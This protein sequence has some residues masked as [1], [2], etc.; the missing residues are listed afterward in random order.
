MNI[1]EISALFSVVLPFLLAIISY[2]I[3][4][5]SKK[6]RDAFVII[7]CG[8]V[9]I[10][11]L[12]VFYGANNGGVSVSICKILCFG[13]YFKADGFRGLYL[14]VASLLWFLSSVFCKSY[15]A[16]HYRNRNRFFFFFL[17]TLG[18]VCGIFLSDDLFTLFIFFEIMSFTSYVWVAHDETPDAMRAAG[19]YLGISVIGGLSILMGLFLLYSEVGTL[20]FD[21]IKNVEINR[22]II[23]SGLTM[24]VGFG[25]KAGMLPLH[26]WLPKAHPI[27][28]APSSALLSG[29]LTKTGIFGIIV[30]T[31][32][33]FIGNRL[34][35]SIIFWLGVATMLHGAILALVSVN[36]K[37][38]LAC[39]SMS[40][41]GF[42][43]TGIGIFGLSDGE[44]TA[45]ISGTALY[46]VNHS[47]FKLLLFTAAGIV[48]TRTH[49]LSLDKIRGIGRNQPVFAALF[50]IGAVGISGV[51]FFSGFVSKTLI[52]EAITEFAAETGHF[53]FKIAEWLFLFAGGMTFAYM[54]KLFVALFIEKGDGEG[55]CGKLSVGEYITLGVPA[56]L[57]VVLGLLPGIYVN[58]FTS[59][60]APFFIGETKTLSFSLL[61][62]EAILSALISISIGLILYFCVVRMILMRKSEG[63]R[64][65]TERPLSTFD[66]ENLVYRP[67][68]LVVLPAV[69]G[70]I[71]SIIDKL[72]DTLTSL[73]KTVFGYIVSTVNS[74]FDF[75]ILIL[76]KTAF[77]QLKPKSEMS[78]DMR[79]SYSIG[80]VIDKVYAFVHRD[81]E[82][83]KTKSFAEDLTK[84]RTVNAAANR[85]ISRSFSFG[86]L[87]TCL[88]VC[89]V[90]VVVVIVFITK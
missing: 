28:P 38:T 39:S 36:I 85:L 32:R 48:Y 10:S 80:T 88:G 19:T 18:A 6:A 35:G 51:P 23:A 86:F 12:A 7:S 83:T 21:A 84:M 30:L 74:I 22:K 9:L 77:S 15:F 41:I 27:A 61:S 57:I 33:L 56:I 64:I 68:L 75:G 3:G 5:K 79:M 44:I 1:F 17:L 31:S 87:M 63:R 81:D 25:A 14:T 90:I 65:Y 55:K 70:F 8:L 71:C 67:I 76:R 42:I 40:Q 43:L 52:H 72:T 45:A 4:R 89:A 20:S 24:L 29:I 49:S 62:G 13:L 54:T 37:R 73:S 26:V 69:F 16:S 46:M 78:V 34:W 11:A 82:E 47:L 59:L 60:I 50:A 2:I 58:G 66:L 53:E